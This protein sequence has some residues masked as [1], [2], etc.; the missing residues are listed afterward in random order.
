MPSRNS[1]K[2]KGL[3]GL[4]VRSGTHV[5]SIT[6]SDCVKIGMTPDTVLL[7]TAAFICTTDLTTRRAGNSRETSKGRKKR[8]GE[9][10]TT[11]RSPTRKTSRRASSPSKSTKSARLARNATA[12]SKALWKFS[13]DTFSVALVLS[14]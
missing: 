2:D 5:G 9:G 8:G 14:R 12:S 3:R 11:L 4:T 7:G 6:T 13:V 1:E 10:S